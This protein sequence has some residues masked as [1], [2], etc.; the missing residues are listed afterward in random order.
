LNRDSVDPQAR[1]DVF[2]LYG[3]DENDPKLVLARVI[4]LELDGTSGVKNLFPTTR[5]FAELKSRLDRRLTAE[6]QSGKLTIEEAHALLAEN[7][8]RASHQYGLRNFGETDPDKV[9]AKEAE[10][11]HW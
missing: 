3:K 8:I 6:V 2:A 1:R 5:W 10:A 9:R 11:K 4:P 7:W